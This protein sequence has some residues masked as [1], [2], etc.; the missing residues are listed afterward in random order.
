MVPA[1][2]ML[3][4]SPSQDAAP[5]RSA[6]LMQSAAAEFDA[7]VGQPRQAVKATASALIQDISPETNVMQRQHAAGDA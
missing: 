1:V 7:A 2:V 6:L 3:V 5:A 4:Q